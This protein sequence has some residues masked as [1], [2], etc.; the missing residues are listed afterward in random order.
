MGT[1]EALVQLGLACFGLTAM[2][3]ALGVNARLRRWAP[4]VGLVGQVFWFTFAWQVHQQGVDVRGLVVLCSA[5]TV[6]YVRGAWV[7]WR[8]SAGGFSL[9]RRG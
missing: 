2:W 5:Y 7:Q 4:I 1:H 6:V 3:W 9:W 8:P